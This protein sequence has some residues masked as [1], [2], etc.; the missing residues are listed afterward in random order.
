MASV[1]YQKPDPKRTPHLHFLVPFIRGFRQEYAFTGYSDDLAHTEE[2][3]E[4]YVKEFN[5]EVF[6]KYVAD[7]IEEICRELNSRWLLSIL[8]CYVDG[9]EEKEVQL[10][11]LAAANAVEFDR[12]H[13]SCLHTL[14]LDREDFAENFSK[15]RNKLE[16]FDGLILY[17]GHADVLNNFYYR[18]EKLITHRE[19]DKIY[20]TLTKRFCN[21]WLSLH[22]GMILNSGRETTRKNRETTIKTKKK[23]ATTVKNKIESIK[24]KLGI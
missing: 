8:Y 2:W 6:F 12:M 11:A 21:S 15:Y 19:I 4:Q 10:Q 5:K 1:E 13:M 7:N 24:L 14:H 9:H 20:R 22:A 3:L 23:V 18:S 17:I 16:V